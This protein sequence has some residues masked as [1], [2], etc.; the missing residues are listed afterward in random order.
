MSIVTIFSGTYCKGDEVAEGVARALDYEAIDAKLL[1]A[2]SELAGV[3]PENVQRAMQ[4]PA[5]WFSSVMRGRERN[6][7]CVRLALA[8]LLQDGDCVYHGFAAH[9]VPRTVSH[10]LRVCVIANHDFRVGE[11]MAALGVSRGKAAKTIQKEDEER[12]QWVYHLLRKKPWEAELYDMVVPMHDRTVEDAVGRICESARSEALR[13]TAASRQAMQD[14]LLAAEVER[15]LV[16]KG[17]RYPVTAADGQIRITI[18]KDVFFLARLEEKLRAAAQGVEGVRDVKV[19]VDTSTQL[20]TPFGPME[21]DA[22]MKVLLVDDEKEFVETLSERLRVRQLRPAVAYDGEQALAAVEQDEPEVMILD[23]K[24]PGIDGME[25]LRR[26]KKTRP[27][28]EVIILTGH[29]SEEDEQMAQELGAF[30]Y[31]EKPVDI[32]VLTNVMKEAYRK[33]HESREDGDGKE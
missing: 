15:A 5:S 11:A 14:F 1:E 23:L 30:A 17:Y 28:V 29:G 27:A 8:R 12:Y 6:I 9:L 21:V 4:G 18:D 16:D 26:L 3:P 13:A 19:R 25:V 20:Q 24:M 22:P 32:A 10:V 2:A 7:A 31:L 33:V